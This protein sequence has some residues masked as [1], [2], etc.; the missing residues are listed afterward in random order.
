MKTIEEIK[1]YLTNERKNGL[2]FVQDVEEFAWLIEKVLKL[3]PKIII[4]IGVES[5]GTL[6]IWKDLIQNDGVVI[7]ID[8]QNKIN[9]FDYKSCKKEV[10]L[11]EGCSYDKKTVDRVY[12]I[13]NGR[14][15]DFVFIDGEHTNF[16]AQKDMDNYGY[17]V[18][19]RGIVGFHDGQD[20]KEMFDKLQGEKEMLTTQ[21]R[22]AYWRK[23]EL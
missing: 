2:Y 13:L 22:T 23:S 6:K 7:G 11:V 15:P 21:Y 8:L 19:P 10:H 12:E 17:L 1:E 14:L 16:A 3:N 4:E 5:G 18:K 9:Q 20:I